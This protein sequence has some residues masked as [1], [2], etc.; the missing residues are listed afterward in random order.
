MVFILGGDGFSF[1]EKRFVVDEETV[2]L[3]MDVG[4][5]CFLKLNNLPVL[6]DIVQPSSVSLVS[7]LHPFA[8]KKE[9]A[10]ETVISI[11]FVR[12]CIWAKSFC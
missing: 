3:Q 10:S 7:I 6:G 8:P 4:M 5:N 11:R 2:F 12:F 9:E 1:R